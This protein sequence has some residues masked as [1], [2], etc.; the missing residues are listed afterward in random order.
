MNHQL[1]A[2]GDFYEN[3]Y[4]FVFEDFRI[5][6][7]AYADSCDKDMDLLHKPGLRIIDKFRLRRPWNCS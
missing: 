1:G 3:I 2:N 6:V 4:F 5:E 7:I